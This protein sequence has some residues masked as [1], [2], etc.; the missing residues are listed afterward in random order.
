MRALILSILVVLGMAFGAGEAIACQ[1]DSDCD[2]GSHCVIQDGRNDGICVNDTPNAPIDEQQTVETPPIDDDGNDG[3]GCRTH[4]DC[5]VG[6]RCVQGA[7]KG[8]M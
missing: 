8:G 3:G 6:G 1:Q 4:E 5:G 2:A 7:C